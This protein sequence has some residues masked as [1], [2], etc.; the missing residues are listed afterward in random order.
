MH[1]LRLALMGLA[2]LVA[3]FLGWTYLAANRRVLGVA[4]ADLAAG[5]RRDAA[6]HRRQR[7]GRDGLRRL[8]RRL[9]AAYPAE[10]EG[11]LTRAAERAAAAGETQTPT[12]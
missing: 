10:Y 8:F 1:T 3:I 7:R 11:F 4:A 12:R 2:A 9:K 6:R 5:R